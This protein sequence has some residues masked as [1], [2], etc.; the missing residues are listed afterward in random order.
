M[1][2]RCRD[3]IRQIAMHVISTTRN[4]W[5]RTLVI[6]LLLAAAGEFLLRGPIRFV[7][8][9]LT[10]NDFLSPYIQADAWVHGKNP[11]ATSS[12]VMLWPSGDPRPDFVTREAANGSL[13][14][15]RGIPSLYPVTSLA[16][17]A[18]LTSLK[19]TAAETLWIAINTTFLLLAPVFLIAI[20]GASWRS[21]RVQFFLAAALALAPL[22]TGL[23]TGN[24]AVLVI[25]LTTGAVWADRRRKAIVS[26]I[27]LALAICLKPTIAVA[28]VLYLLLR[29]HWRVF[30]VASAVTAVVA[31]I[32][33]GWLD[34]ERVAWLA[35]YFDN[36]RKILASG[37][38]ADFTS[39]DPL[40]FNLVNTQVL[41]YS[42]FGSVSLAQWL[43]FSLAAALL[44]FWLSL[45]LR[46][47]SLSDESHRQDEFLGISTLFV[48]SLLPVYHRF[49]DAGLLLWPLAWA[50]LVAER[51]RRQL[52][53]MLAI[54]PFFAPGAALLDRWTEQGRIP[55]RIAHSGCWNMI[56]MPHEIWSLIALSI[57][58]LLWMDTSSRSGISQEEHSVR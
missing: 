40:R 41:F 45:S 51:G 38:L 10:W 13:P 29:R 31:A 48:I 8:S 14:A 57:L 39:A 22:H 47:R 20:S 54:V 53:T 5:I 27:L 9:Q 37:G 32:A 36:N 33:A 12:I 3:G 58:L 17:L 15:K 46:R 52:W 6:V 2:S 7:H 24:P 4:P 25:A 35:S 11:Y 23:A 43:S 1:F 56:V 44:A 34:H 55:Q 28:L 16:L 18:P 26:G 30:A 49:Y 50:L 42:L 21:L 19:W